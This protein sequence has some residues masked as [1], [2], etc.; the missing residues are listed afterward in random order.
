MVCAAAF[1]G[2]GFTCPFT[3]A[4]VTLPGSRGRTTINPVGTEQKNTRR[5]KKSESEI[6][7]LTADVCKRIPFISV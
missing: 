2:A 3:A 1:V 5:K 4:A 6:H 7:V